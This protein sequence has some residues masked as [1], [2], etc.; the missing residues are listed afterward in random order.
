MEGLGPLATLADA[1]RHFADPRAALGLIASLRWPGGVRCPRCGSGGPALL[2]SRPVWKCRAK[3]CRKQFSVRIGTILED[4]PIG[5]HTWLAYLWAVASDKDRIGSH[6]A[7]RA[8]GITQK[9][10][11]YMRHRIRLAMRTRAFAAQD[12]SHGGFPLVASLAADAAITGEAQAS[13]ERLAAF[14]RRLLAVPKTEI[15]REA[16]EWVRARRHVT[17]T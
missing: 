12:D 13:L 15:D 7:A 14:T 10:A 4:S 17:N 16:S 2:S 1:I 9:S 5:L 11:W 3:E 6:R 8:M